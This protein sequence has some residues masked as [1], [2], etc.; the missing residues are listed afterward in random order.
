MRL[1]NSFLRQL[2]ED[3]AQALQNLRR[4]QDRQKEY[5]DRR[6][7]DVEF[8]VGDEVLLSTRTLPM[9]VAAGGMQKVG[10][11]LYT[12]LSYLS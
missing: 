7:R 2:E 6:R 8:Q 10:L 11:D 4:A 5:A 3:V 1:Q 9:K 12:A